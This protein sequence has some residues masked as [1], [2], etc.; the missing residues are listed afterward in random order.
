MENYLFLYRQQD[1]NKVMLLKLPI[2]TSA[3]V[4]TWQGLFNG[5]KA[6]LLRVVSFTQ[7]AGAR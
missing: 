7:L 5:F 2:G 6:E 1:E 4:E 3:D